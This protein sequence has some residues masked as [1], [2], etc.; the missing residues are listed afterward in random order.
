MERH[1][2]LLVEDD[3][4]TRAH[5]ADAIEA[6]ADFEL[7]G[8]AASCAEARALAAQTV[9]RVLVTDLGLPDGTGADLIRELR[10][11]HPGMLCMV[12]SVFGDERNVIDALSAGA[13]GY[14]L[15]G[16]PGTEIGESIRQL[17][18]G[19]S[20]ISAPIARYLLA[21]FE[22]PVERPAADALSA[23]ETEVLE[24]IAKGFSGPEI[25]KLLHVSP[26]TVASHVRAIYRKLEVRSTGEAVYEA[27][28]RG[29]LEP[30]R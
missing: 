20:P 7:A 27:V 18:G 14:L 24:L 12:I 21:R 30:G 19:G 17:I 3:E 23:R 6:C 16:A 26:H 11:R 25:A 1:P 13:R 29:I 2:V 4:P 22:A 28:S 5:L 10:P 15:K 9:P 8:V